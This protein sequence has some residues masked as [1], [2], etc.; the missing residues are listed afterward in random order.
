MQR[1]LRSPVEW[2][3]SAVTGLTFAA[4]LIFGANAA[5]ADSVEDIKKKGTVTIGI[6]GDNPPWGFVNASRVQDGFD[7]DIGKLFAAHLGV[8]VTFVPLLGR[9][10]MTFRSFARL[11]RSKSI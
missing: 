9:V 7:A 6:Q 10:P 8:N 1:S 2:R 11:P 4:A 3:K 5:R